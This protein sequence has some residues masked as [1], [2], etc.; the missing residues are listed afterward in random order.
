MNS[1]IESRMITRGYIMLIERTTELEELNRMY[2]KNSFEIAVIYGIWYK[3][4]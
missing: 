1:L 2:N 4:V 3:S